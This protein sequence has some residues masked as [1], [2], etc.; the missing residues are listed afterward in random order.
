MHYNIL[1]A[2][3]VNITSFTFFIVLVLQ[4][5]T[6]AVVLKPKYNELNLKVLLFL[7]LFVLFINVYILLFTFICVNEIIFIIIIALFLYFVCSV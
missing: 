5:A 3:R 2:L 4:L 7:L 1:F 6:I